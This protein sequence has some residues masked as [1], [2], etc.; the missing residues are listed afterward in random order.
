MEEGGE[1]GD[2]AE[3]GEAPLLRGSPATGRGMLEVGFGGKH[4][5]RISGSNPSWKA[6][7]RKQE[8]DPVGLSRVN[9]MVRTC[10]LVGFESGIIRYSI[11]LRT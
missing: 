3:E 4:H 9:K 6:P 1:G 5:D 11:R 8:N 10:R 2:A 7:R